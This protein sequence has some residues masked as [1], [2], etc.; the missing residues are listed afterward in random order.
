MTL[1]VT[2]EFSSR[3]HS[4]LTSDRPSDGKT[5]RRGQAARRQEVCGE[6]KSLV[7]YL[8]LFFTGAAD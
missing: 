8:V 3:F 1:S 4:A 6:E 2:S 7:R 5:G